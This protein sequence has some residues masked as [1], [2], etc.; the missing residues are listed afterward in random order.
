MPTFWEKVSHLFG[1]GLVVW[2]N[3]VWSPALS[4]TP[5]L[6]QW[7]V[8]VVSRFSFCPM[9]RVVALRTAW[10]FTCHDPSCFTWSIGSLFSRTLKIAKP[11]FVK[12]VVVPWCNPLLVFEYQVLTPHPS[13]CIPES[14]FLFQLLE[15]VQTEQQW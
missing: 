12:S 1:L 5:F 6:L 10:S 9:L 4:L 13:F 8:K 14:V 7:C 11:L 15:R 2:S 3:L